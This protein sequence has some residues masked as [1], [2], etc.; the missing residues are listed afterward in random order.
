MSKLALGLY[1][2]EFSQKLLAEKIYTAENK[3][4]E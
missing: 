4:I 3:D 2:G 1:T